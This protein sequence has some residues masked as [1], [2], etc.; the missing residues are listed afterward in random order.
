MKT[1]LKKLISQYKTEIKELRKNPEE[2]KREVNPVC[3]GAMMQ[4]KTVILDLEAL[5]KSLD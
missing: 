2:C 1:K 4:L 5:L 3:H